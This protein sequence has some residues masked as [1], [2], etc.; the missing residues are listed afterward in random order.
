MNRST[1]ELPGCRGRRD[2]ST[3]AL[4]PA[5][6]PTEPV[7]PPAKRRPR[8]DLPRDLTFRCRMVAV[9]YGIF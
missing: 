1:I 7:E 2:A 9:L 8:V 4:A 5:R 6:R 3:R